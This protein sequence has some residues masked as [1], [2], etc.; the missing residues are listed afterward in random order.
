MKI[1]LFSRSYNGVVGG[2]E[3]LSLKI[4]EVY[5]DIGWDVHLV[6]LDPP[7]AQMYFDYPETLIWH[8]IDLGET[9][10]VASWALRLKRIRAL[11]QLLREIKPN[12]FIAF[13]V[14]SFALMRVSAFGLGIRSI[15]AE[16]NAPTLFKFI[17]HGK[18]KYYFYQ[19]ILQLSD[20]ISVQFDSYRNLYLRSLRSRIVVTP[21]I[22]KIH[23][24]KIVRNGSHDFLKIL[25]V[26]RV[27][28]QKNL[29]ILISAFN[30]DLDNK[31]EL[32]IVGEGSELLSIQ[33]MYRGD[34]K[35]LHV[36]PFQKDLSRFYQDA[37]LLC[38]PSRWEG[39]PNVVAEAMGYGLPVIGFKECAG[40]NSLVIPGLNGELVD[41]REPESLFRCLSQFNPSQYFPDK[42]QES[43]VKY[44][45]ALFRESWL[46]AA[47]LTQQNQSKI[48]FE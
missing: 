17:K 31:L 16:R 39:F 37:D 20:V 38:L 7:T 11:R 23:P 28:Y 46:K 19:T 35:F 1:V 42:I 2:I 29:D 48:S 4:A 18:F 6:S 34:L 30:L 47:L 25:Y 44:D 22:V 27:T 33:D 13:Q 12:L 3:R 26:G 41:E 21:N 15:A 9:D 43:V 8:K 10:K 40:V 14:G 24:A 32:T 5:T 45:D 36:F